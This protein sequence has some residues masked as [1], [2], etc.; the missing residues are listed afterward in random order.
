MTL[1]VILLG[2]G[3]IVVNY[4][5][6]SLS[7]K[8]DTYLG[9]TELETALT[10]AGLMNLMPTENGNRKAFFRTIKQLERDKGLSFTV[11]K[12]SHRDIM[13]SVHHGGHNL[14]TYMIIYGEGGTKKLPI[15]LGSKSRN[16]SK[17]RTGVDQTLFAEVVDVLN[18]CLQNPGVNG[19]TIHLRVVDYL[20]IN[21]DVIESRPTGVP[22]DLQE[23]QS[24]YFI[25]NETW[26]PKLQ[27]LEVIYE[28]FGMKVDMRGVLMVLDKAAGIALELDGLDITDTEGTK[29]KAEAR[30]E[31]A[32]VSR[33]LLELADLVALAESCIRNEYWVMKGR[34]V[35]IE[36]GI[37]D[38]G[39]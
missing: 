27:N 12:E 26:L 18:K 13:W 24:K 25:M 17:G 36:I 34:G 22:S 8:F 9:R 20:K 6:V 10:A 23:K 4:Y 29:E 16:I 37:W 7:P 1:V 39:A 38:D 31:K 2:S 5:R 30:S 21:A 28:K 32:E 3:A 14:G 15:W 33:K 19:Y 35:D 11:L